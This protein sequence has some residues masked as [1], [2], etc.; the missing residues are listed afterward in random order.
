[1]P[2]YGFRTE[3]SSVDAGTCNAGAAFPGQPTQ[4]DR[5]ALAQVEY[6]G[7]LHFDFGEDWWWN[8]DDDVPGRRAA[9]RSHTHHFRSDGTWVVFADAGRGWLVGTPDGG[10]LIYERDKFPSF[11]TFR[12]DIGAG[13][14]F[15]GIGFY[16]AKAMSTAGEPVRFFLRL[17]H[18]F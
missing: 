10:S 17:R 13:F 11:S 15:G 5:I 9:H 14:D 18:R 1:M 6:R 12:T 4:C 8:D 3:R 16:V 2:G 7:D